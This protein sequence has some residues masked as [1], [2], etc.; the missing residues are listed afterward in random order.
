MAPDIDPR[1]GGIHASTVLPLREDF[2][3]DEPQL[4]E[5]VALV[6]STPGVRGLLINGHAGENFLL[7]R[8][9]KRRVVEI[10]RKAIP[11]DRVIVCGVNAE[12]SLEAAAESCAAEEAG[13]DALIVF[14]PNGWALNQDEEMALV[15]HRY[16]AEASRLPLFLYQAPITAGKMAY[17]TAILAKLISLPTVIGIKEGSWEVAAYEEHR[18]LVKQLRPEVLVLASGDEHLL[19]SYLIGTEGSQVSLAAVVP[20]VVVGLFEAAMRGDWQ[21]AHALH[22]RLYPLAVAIYRKAPSGRANARLKTC[23]RL[24]GRISSDR[25]RPPFPST[26]PSE[27]EGLKQALEIALKDS[28]GRQRELLPT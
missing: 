28:G 15:H 25:V 14:P 4:K 17:S 26:P 13:A 19:T 23:L 6:A 11:R 5:H 20:D 7:N 9:E 16:V 21:R 3:I 12:S 8:E 24:M 22:A 18:R 27:I 10:V 2:T 1:F